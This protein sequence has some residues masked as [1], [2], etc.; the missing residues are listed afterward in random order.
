AI[1]HLAAASL[2]KDDSRDFSPRVGFA[3]DIGSTGRH[4]ARGG[5]GLYYGQ[6]FLNIPLFMIQQINPTIFVSVFSIASGDLVPGTGIQLSNWRFGID[7]LPTIP[8][9]PTQL[10]DGST[11]RIM[12]PDYQNPLTQQWNVGY[13]WALNSYSVLEFEYTHILGLHES[14]TVN[15]NPT[16]AMFLDSAGNEITSRPLT[17]ALTAAHQPILGR[18]DL[19][20]SSGRS[21][22]D[23]MNISYCRRLHK[24]FTV[25]ATYTLSRALAYNGNSAAFRNRGWDPFN[26]FAANE[27]GP[28]PNDSRHR[29]SMGSVVNLPWGF[30]VA[31]IMQ[32][33]SARPYTAG[34]GAAVDILGVG[35]GRGTSHV[36]VFKDRPNDL[37]ATLTAFGDPGASGDAGAANRVAFRK[38]LRSGQCTHGNFDDFR[39]QLSFQLDARVTKNFKIKERANLQAIFQVFDL[40]N[41]ANFGNNYVTDVRQ[42]NFATP[43]NFITPSGVTVPHSLSAE[44]GL[45]IT[46]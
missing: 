26:F 6:T 2:P 10:P 14:K 22:Y 13:A 21:R 20:Q 30:Q 7:P 43:S 1:N 9:P 37:T 19:E 42:S 45:R 36:V 39:R 38:C 18:I 40:T 11:G 23:G 29:F 24:G 17:A 46:F 16:R 27:L 32:W 8:P 41:R 4:V 34:Y 5:Y 31:P 25:N 35:G 28:T 44:F 3:W 15:I 33:E 12:D